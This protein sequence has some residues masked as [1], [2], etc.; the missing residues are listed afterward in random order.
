MRHTVRIK[1]H[2]LEQQLFLRRAI[3]IGGL[4]AAAVIVLMGRLI[5]LQ[6]MQY[7]YYYDLSQ[8]NRIRNEPLPPNRGLIFDRNGVA[9]GRNAPTYQLELTREQVPDL[10]A[11]LHDLAE[12][13]L[14][15]GDDLPALKR[16]IEG[17]RAFEAVPLKL[18]LSDDELAR[19][20][21]RQQEFPGVEIRW[22]MARTYPLS[23]SAVHAIGYVSAISTDDQKTINMDDYEGTTL[24]GKSGVERAYEEQLHGTKGFRQLLVNAQ[25]RSVERA[26]LKLPDLKLK[27]P[28]AGNDLYLTLDQR[29]QQE[30]EK[31]MQDRRGA[32]IAIDPNNGDVIALVSTPG[33]DPNLFARGIS[34][35]DYR[36]LRDD[37]DVPL[38]NRALAGTYPSGSTIKPFMALAALQYGVMTPDNTNYCGGKF[39]LP[40]VARPWRDFKPEGHGYIDM[41]HAI[42]QSCDVYFYH[43]AD[44]LGIDRIHDL[45]EQFGLGQPVGLDISG[46]KSGILPSTD[47]KRRAFR[48]PA[49]QKWYPGETIN[50]GIGQGYLSVTPIQLAQATAVLA[51][52]GKSYRPRLVRAVRKSINDEMLQPP[53]VELPPV[54]IANPAYWQVVIEGM[55]AVTKGSRG[56]A[57]GAFA[58]AQYDVAGKTGTAQAIGISQYENIKAVTKTL[59]DRTRDHGWFIAFAPVDQ[60][61][62]AVA[63]IVENGGQG[64]SA[65]GPVARRIFDTYL[66]TAD[67][68]KEQD[69][70]GRSPG[71]TV[72]GEGE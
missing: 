44:V 60:P 56:T 28:V 19:F 35:Q 66:L 10:D 30:V 47:W 29:V 68:L 43:V 13:K 20:A 4:M 26:G 67:Q 65:A 55:L 69:Q 72:S 36:D 59:G 7:D 71:I 53:P 6:V 23:S 17:R 61:K 14:L 38:Y 12:L 64:G 34:R 21:V 40:G 16:D 27:Q 48:N 49:D 50:V 3:V 11:T 33:F 15:D 24:I 52:R 18:Q 45:L 62:I 41:R 25:G 54:K 22:R 70:K 42:E 39:R 37:L 63:V 46:E 8:G 2:F 31:I 58:T 57:R 5:W 32:A 51:A 9:L 1:D